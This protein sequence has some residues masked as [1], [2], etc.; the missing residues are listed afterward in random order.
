LAE[1]QTPLWFY[2]LAEAE[3]RQQGLQLGEV[4][5]RIS[6]ETLIGLLVA[7]PFSF[8]S[9]DPTWTPAREGKIPAAGES[10]EM[11]DLIR[12]TRN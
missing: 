6:A 2:V 5:A 8:C 4:G 12:F 9:V 10:F 11:A 1:G 7:D 3:Q